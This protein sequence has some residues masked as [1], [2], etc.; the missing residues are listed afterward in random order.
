MTV[1]TVK[2]AVAGVLFAACGLVAASAV[3]E[4]ASA[5]RTELPARAEVAGVQPD[6]LASAT[7]SRDWTETVGTRTTITRR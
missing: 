4:T 3:A 1:K 5:P 7:T 2:L 6:A